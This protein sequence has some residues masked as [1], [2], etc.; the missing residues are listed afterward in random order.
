ML[1]VRWNTTGKVWLAQQLP[2]FK[3]NRLDSD[4]GRHMY[5]RHWLSHTRYVTG[6][7]EWTQIGPL[8][9]VQW[10]KE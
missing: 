8:N 5:G 4:G 7:K 2:N 1:L 10:G 6:S 9:M 3:F